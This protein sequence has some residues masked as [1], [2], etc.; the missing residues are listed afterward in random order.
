MRLHINDKNQLRTGIYSI[1]TM[2][3]L[4]VVLSHVFSGFYAIAFRQCPNTSPYNMQLIHIDENA[5][6]FLDL[7]I[8]ADIST[9]VTLDL[10]KNTAKLGSDIFSMTTFKGKPSND[11]EKV[12][13][14][15]MFQKAAASLRSILRVWND[16]C[17]EDDLKVV[18]SMPDPFALT[19]LKPLL[20][21]YH[22]IQNEFYISSSEFEE[23]QKIVMKIVQFYMKFDKD[24]NYFRF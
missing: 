11:R 3:Y 10:I 9:D 16:E 19:R 4:D 23:L 15:E 5:E 2:K 7:S 24:I 22:K 12:K 8:N 20:E 14:A 6:G 21:K 1:E 13:N 17:S 18:G